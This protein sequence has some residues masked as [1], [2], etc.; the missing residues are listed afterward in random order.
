MT[1]GLQS[2]VTLEPLHALLSRG[3]P[4]RPLTSP[5]HTYHLSARSKH[6]LITKFYVCSLSMP[7]SAKF[8]IEILLKKHS[9]LFLTFLVCSMLSY[10]TQLIICIGSLI[11][12]ILIY[13]QFINSSIYILILISSFVQKNLITLE[14]VNDL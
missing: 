12:N 10:R 11:Q 5:T 6:I 3:C 4:G 9:S 13:Q 8:K 2:S 1:L 7:T 14:F